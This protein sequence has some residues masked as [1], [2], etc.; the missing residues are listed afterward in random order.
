M[1]DLPALLD[2]V[3]TERDTLRTLLSE[4]RSTRL[5]IDRDYLASPIAGVMVQVSR[6]VARLDALAAKLEWDHATLVMAVAAPSTVTLISHGTVG[7][8]RE[9]V[10]VA[11]DLT[12]WLQDFLAWAIRWGEELM[13]EPQERLLN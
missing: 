3:A 4:A 10:Q 5:W 7:A 13:D 11:H 8:I 9:R 2:E 6:D 1:S 12:V